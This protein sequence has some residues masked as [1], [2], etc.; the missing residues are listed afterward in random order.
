MNNK[1][2]IIFKAVI[3]FLTT[4][5]KKNQTTIKIKKQ[6]NLKSKIIKNIIK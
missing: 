3:V 2:D 1:I 6:T 4:K 5:N